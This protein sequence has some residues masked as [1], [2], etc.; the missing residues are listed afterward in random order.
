MVSE[1]TI[2][3]LSLYRRLLAGLL[4]DNRQSIFSR[5]LAS[6]AGGTAPQVRRDIMSIGYSGSPASGYD[7]ADLADSIGSFLDNPSG[8]SGVIVGA[9]NLGRAI[10]SFF[11]SRRPLLKLLAAFDN[12]PSKIDTEICGRPCYDI[13]DLEAKVSELGVKMGVITVPAPIAQETSDKL[14]SAGVA[15]ILNFAPIRLHVPDNV[16]VEHVDLTTSMEKVAY[17]V[18]SKTRSTAPDA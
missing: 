10:M 8:T 4:D 14:V 9:G 3:R 2:E 12:D 1:K 5:E 6:L 16:Y 11:V 17:F 7:I 18:Q 13:A 15:G